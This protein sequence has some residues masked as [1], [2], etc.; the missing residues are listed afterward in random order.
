MYVGI[1][2]P[3]FSGSTVVGSILHRFN[4]VQHIGEVWKIFADNQIEKAFCR[5]CGKAPCPYFSERFKAELR[6]VENPLRIKKL[7]ERFAVR[8]IVSGDKKPQY[9]ERYTGMPDR[10]LV[11][12]KNKYAA[13]L[14]FANRINGFS[15]NLSPSVMRGYI[16]SAVD[17]YCV[18]LTKRI[19]WCKRNF[20]DSDIIFAS[21]EIIVELTDS[22]FVEFGRNV[23]LEDLGLKEAMIDEKFHYIGGNHKISRGKDYAYFMGSIKADRRYEAIFDDSIMATVDQLTDEK[24]GLKDVV[25]T[26]STYLQSWVAM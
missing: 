26:C 1:V 5:E 21:P 18:E 17:E 9:Y 25:G 16:V 19:S 2:C 4:A 22:G 11:L 15:S 7:K 12:I 23:F 14:S 24:Y 8:H 20:K 6:A 13:A 10:V 3:N